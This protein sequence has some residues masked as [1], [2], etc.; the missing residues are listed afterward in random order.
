MATSFDPGTGGGDAYTKYTE[1]WLRS[2]LPK[3]E[4]LPTPII[5]A[6]KFIPSRGGFAP[7]PQVQRVDYTQPDPPPWG[8]RGGMLPQRFPTV[9]QY[10]RLFSDSPYSRGGFL[11]YP[12]GQA[13]DI[14][15][16]SGG[17]GR[18]GGG[19]SVDWAGI[20]QRY[21]EMY[22]KYSQGPTFDF[23]VTGPEQE[24][25]YNPPDYTPSNGG[26][27]T[28]KFGGGGTPSSNIRYYGTGLI[29]WRV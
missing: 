5:N 20:R 24:Q 21:E 7:N 3:I 17:T 8:S 6:N 2:Q 29:N 13:T 10:P 25:I 4:E 28:Y 15:R 26:G 12:A 11:P 27:Y 22:R 14:L 18:T 1:R 16:E 9:P 19:F 23:Q